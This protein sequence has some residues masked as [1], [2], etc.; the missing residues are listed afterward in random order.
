MG[1]YPSRVPH[2]RLKN[3]YRI[4]VL[5]SQVV[6]SIPGMFLLKDSKNVNHI[7]VLLSYVVGFI[8]SMLLFKD[9][10]MFMDFYDFSTISVVQL[11]KNLSL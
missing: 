10:S 3:V 1:V 2:Q 6:G 5:L 11:K 7:G 8:P 4:G 9:F